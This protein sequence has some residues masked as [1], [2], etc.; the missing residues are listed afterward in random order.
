VSNRLTWSFD[1]VKRTCSSLVG[2]I[3]ST[4][5]RVPDLRLEVRCLL[6]WLIRWLLWPFVPND[7][8]F[9]RFQ[10]DHTPHH[11]PFSSAFFCLLCSSVR[12]RFRSLAWLKSESHRPCYLH[13]QKLQNLPLTP[14]TAVGN[15]TPTLLWIDILCFVGISTAKRY[16]IISCICDKKYNW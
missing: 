3:N 16:L 12:Y 6:S 1:V 11:I 5:T 7:T 15:T 10:S 2:L 4:Y 8:I 9:I 13:L 14:F